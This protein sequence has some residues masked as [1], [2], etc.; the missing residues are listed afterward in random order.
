MLQPQHT[1]E[2][3]LQ[4]TITYISKFAQIAKFVQI[5]KFDLIILLIFDATIVRNF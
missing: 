5:A 3:L 1:P 2:A 4:R